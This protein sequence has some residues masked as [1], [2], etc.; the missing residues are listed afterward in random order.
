MLSATPYNKSYLDLSNQLRLFVPEDMDI[1]IR[2]E[3]LLRDLGELKFAQLHQCPIRSL[4]AFEKSPHADDWR[5]VMR[6]YL[7]RR[8][9]SF[10][11]A[12]YALTDTENG[13]KYLTY[14]NGNRAYF[15]TRLPKT[16]KF[17]I[18]DAN[19]DDKYAE[20]Y[21][22][23]VVDIINALN[24]PRYGLGNYILDKPAVPPTGAEAD[25]LANLSRA[26][27]RL[28]GFCRTNL[29]KRLESSGKV[30]LQSIERHILRNYIFLHAIVN[31]LPL[32]IGTQDSNLL[33]MQFVDDDDDD[34]TIGLF[35]EEDDTP[36]S[37]TEA[38]HLYTEQDFW[39]RA[40]IV[41]EDYHTHFQRRFKW[42]RSSLF[43]KSLADCLMADSQ[44]LLAMLQKCGEWNP[45]Q[46]TKLVALLDLLTVQHP[47][48]KVLLFTQFADTARYLDSEL[49][50][51][52]IPNVAG[53][54]GGSYD[55]TSY[56]WQFSPHSNGK[57]SQIMPEDELRVLLATDVL[58]EGQNLQDCAIVV[59][60]DLPWAIIRLVQRAGRVD[61]IGQQAPNILCYSFLPADGVE[62]IIK[63]RARVRQRLLEN[64]EV[65][66]TDEAFFEDDS[67]THTVL[68]LYNE[69]AGILDGESDSEVDLAS[70]AYQIWKNAID[71]DPRLQKLIPA[72][73]SVVYSA[74]STEVAGGSIAGKPAN[75]QQLLE[76]G[77]SPVQNT[78]PMLEPAMVGPPGVLVY[79]RTAQDNDALAW[80]DLDGHSVTESQFTIL[81]AAECRPET[82]ALPRDP[83]HHRLVLRGAEQIVKEE[84]TLGGQLGRRSGARYRVYERLKYYASDIKDTL[85]QYDELLKA[86]DDLY[87]YP[88]RQTA[89]DT[90]NRRI[91]A[92]I[93][94]EHLAELV[95][96]LRADD[97]LCQIH[98]QEQKREPQ[99]ICSLGLNNTQKVRN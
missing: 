65:V 26:G 74:R 36:P 18:D 4:S 90:L 42:I 85:F 12:N 19:P 59:N 49:R 15:P 48:E 28:M 52:Q 37:E 16:I 62:L 54:T 89:A 41:Y 56:A 77:V 97:R 51:R 94:D 21:A 91:K 24:V 6:L 58:S 82:P 83:K 60:Y 40:A 20:L 47:N 46:D 29:F 30:F 50:K 31:D 84:S 34:R 10:I 96:S 11:Q 35:G 2:P 78:L 64:E 43:S 5:D 75:S 67:S 81:K 39:S 45:E 88:L 33:D 1:G 95:I 55:P 22:P 71:A 76:L 63:L 53:V 17:T 57:S 92:G 98:D 3:Q 32:P 68:D 9:R 69:K 7:V 73:P 23:G 79:L 44:A 25:R 13:R 80:I 27:R 66:G 70:Y 72:L 99:I 61:R 38:P 87:K 14:E 86:I 93:S 8:T